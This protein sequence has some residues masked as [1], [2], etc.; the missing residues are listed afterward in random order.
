MTSSPPWGSQYRNLEIR[1]QMMQY[2]ERRQL[3]LRHR[4]SGGIKI[5][6]LPVMIWNIRQPGQKCARGQGPWITSQAK[7][8]SLSI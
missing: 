8:G 3:R 7:I 6:V 4:P 1:T 5:L 2:F